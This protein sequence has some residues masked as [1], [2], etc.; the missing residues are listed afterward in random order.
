[1]K[2]LKYFES[3]WDG[4]SIYKPDIKLL[5][6]IDLL[7]YLLTDEGFGLDIN[8]SGRTVYIN[9]TSALINKYLLDKKIFWNNMIKKELHNRIRNEVISKEYFIEYCS[10]VSD[11]LKENK[12]NLSSI[13]I[14][15]ISQFST[16]PTITNVPWRRVIIRISIINGDEVELYNNEHSE[17]PKQNPKFKKLI[18]ESLS[19]SDL[20][21]KVDDLLYIIQ[22][23][24]IQIECE[25]DD[26]IIINITE[27]EI[28][29]FIEDVD[30]LSHAYGHGQ[31]DLVEIN[32][33]KSAFI[34]VKI[35][36]KDFFKEF[37]DRLVEISQEIT[38]NTIFIYVCGIQYRKIRNGKVYDWFGNEITQQ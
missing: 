29:E 36:D 33:R 22:D 7:S 28:E 4:S 21:S 3:R 34:T 38:E 30:L 19:Q 27:N 35:G 25:V 10:R 20:K 15:I 23:E 14:P 31:R 16:V 1:M 8:F 26:S 5:D 6:E 37:V 13:K 9:L 11:E 12:E 24:N 18:K 2:Y 17:E 32:K